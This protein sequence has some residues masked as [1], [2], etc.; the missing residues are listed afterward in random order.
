MARNTFKYLSLIF[1]SFVGS[2]FA[3]A[4]EEPSNIPTSQNQLI[5]LSDDGI[6]PPTLRMKLEDSIVFLLNESKDSLATVRIDYGGKTTH[7]A[8]S[9]LTVTKNKEVQSKRPFGPHDFAS[10][11]FH[12]KGT[13]PV[14][15]FG[16]KKNPTGI[17]SQIVVE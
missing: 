10:V 12:E 5:K 15:I 2:N 16:L 11:C 14:T 17:Q 6:E 8:S 9:N 7:C 1:F 4:H 13:Y 3:L